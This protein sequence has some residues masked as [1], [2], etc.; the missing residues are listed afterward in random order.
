MTPRR[1]G[2][3]NDMPFVRE[4][5]ESKY[6]RDLSNLL[7]RTICTVLNTDKEEVY[8]VGMGKVVL[9]RPLYKL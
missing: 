2:K 4:R 1:S 8:T 7:S 6:K 5:E 3:S 9:R